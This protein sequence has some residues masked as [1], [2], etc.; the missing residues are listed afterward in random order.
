MI[1]IIYIKDR[2]CKYPCSV[3][4]AVHRPVLEKHILNCMIS[5]IATEGTYGKAMR[6]EATET[7]LGDDVASTVDHRDTIVSVMSIISIDG[8]VLAG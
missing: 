4:R 5:A 3:N 7:V 8:D 2:E 6:G 1:S